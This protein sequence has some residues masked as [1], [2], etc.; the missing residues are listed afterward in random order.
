MTQATPPADQ[1][2][3]Q[4]DRLGR[5]GDGV[6][7]MPDGRRVLVPL[8]LPG[9]VVTGDIIDGRLPQPR[10]ITPSPHR[11]RPPC[12]HYRACGGCQLMHADDDFVARWKTGVVD[13]ALAAQGVSGRV[14]AMHTSPRHSRRRAVFSVRRTK[15]GALAGFHARASDVIIDLSDCLVTHPKIIAALP[16][17]RQM[18]QIGASRQGEISVTVSHSPAGLDIAV[19]GG[20]PATPELLASLA[21]IAQSQDWARLVWD[22]A[23]LT[24]RPPAQPFGAAQVVPPPAGFLQATPQGEATLL[25]GVQRAIHGAS[26]IL[27]LFAG[28]GTFSLPLA[29]QAQV[30]AVE[31]LAAPLAALDAG[32]RRASGLHRMTT[33]VRDLARRPLLCDELNRFDGIVIDPPRAGAEAQAHQ[34]ARSTVR[35]LAWVSC[36][37]VTFARDSK[38]LQN[39]GWEIDW[40]EAVD[41]FR[42][43]AHIETVAS[44]RR[45]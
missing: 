18:A 26:H 37:P 38:I 21:V 31:G 6:A 12:P 27:D 36:D 29:A 10:I 30:H 15:K 35:R 1:K 34:I 19:A 11:I 9:E 13:N 20:K 25:A 4:I 39:G 32:W 3:F 45:P 7:T 24:R 16:A 40:I 22:D 23:P 14:S 41:Q 17:L 8:T 2:P 43:S 28:C 44:F 5:R 33:E 42:W